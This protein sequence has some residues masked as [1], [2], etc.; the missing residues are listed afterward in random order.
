MKAVIYARYSSDRQTADSIAAQVRAC[1]EYAEKKEISIVNIYADEAI[2]GKESM[3]Q[4]RENYQK[5]LVDAKKHQFDIVLIHKIDRMSRSTEE[6]YR[7]RAELEKYGVTIIAVAQ[8]FGDTNE[9]KFLTNITYS[10]SEYYIANL[11][12]ETK[13]GHRETALKAL[14]NGGYAPFG[15]DVVNQ[16]YV[17]NELEAGYVRKMFQCALEQKSTKDL[18]NEMHERGIHGKRGKEIKRTQIY[19]ILRNERYT[20]V[21]LYSAT[22]EKN[23]SDRRSKPNA[24]RIENAFPAIIDKET[25]DKVQKIMQTRKRAGRKADYLCSGLVYCGNCG[26][27]MHVYQS[28]GK[29]H[30]YYFYRCAGQC[31][32]KGIPVDDVD[33]VSKRYLEALLSEDTQKQVAG[34]LNAYRGKEK[35]SAK[36]FKK[37]QINVKAIRLEE[38][39]T[40]RENSSLP[41]IVFKELVQQEWEDSDLFNYLFL[42]STHAHFDI[43]TKLFY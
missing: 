32:M 28:C 29:G 24:I 20:G 37:A 9:G 40:M 23:R 33:A 21:Y 42:P 10:M 43:S 31:G 19:E 11:A 26:C 8:D 2:S 13:K 12:A 41:N 6:H 34:V 27:K 38:N 4:R 16:K 1:K 5:M 25:Y 7:V 17:I 39:G 35:D 22:E 18:V 15:Y 3:T 30:T 14:H 36:E